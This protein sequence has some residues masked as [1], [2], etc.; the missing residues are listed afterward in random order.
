M[1]GEESALPVGDAWPRESTGAGKSEAWVWLERGAGHIGHS[2]EYL[3]WEVSESQVGC[4]AEQTITEM[5][6]SSKCT[7]QQ[8]SSEEDFYNSYLL[9]LLTDIKRGQ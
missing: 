1:P 7:R 6:F 5:K 4:L 2:V 8:I 3:H 9:Y